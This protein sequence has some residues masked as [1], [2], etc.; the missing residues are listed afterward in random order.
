MFITD[1][2]S[3]PKLIDEIIS[4]KMPLTKKTGN[5]RAKPGTADGPCDDDDDDD[6]A[7]P[8]VFSKR[9]TTANTTGIAKNCISSRLL[10]RPLRSFRIM[11]RSV[12]EKPRRENVSL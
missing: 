3:W 10:T 4:A 6:E 8:N 7:A 9:R 5:V 12:A 1:L 11:A 2:P